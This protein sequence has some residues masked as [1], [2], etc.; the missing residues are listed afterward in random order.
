MRDGHYRA[1]SLPRNAPALVLWV[2]VFNVRQGDRVTLR[3]VAPDGKEAFINTAT[4]PKNQAR[5]YIF[6]GIRR[7][8]PAWMTGTWRGEI[9]LEPRDGPILTTTRTIE[10]R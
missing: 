10:I 2:D 5:R 3:M 1:P 9:P 8:T 4:V 7:K 6:G